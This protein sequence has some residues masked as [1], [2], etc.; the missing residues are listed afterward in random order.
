VLNI[1]EKRGG[2]TPAQ[3]ADVKTK[4][5]TANS[6]AT[7]LAELQTSKAL[8]TQPV[9][10]NGTRHDLSTA[11]SRQAALTRAVKQRMKADGCDYDTAYQRVKA[12]PACAPIF[13]AMNPAK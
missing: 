9:E 6:R 4:L 12:D 2:I 5:A 11:N 3:R 1:A 10:I 7:T 8:N 13:A